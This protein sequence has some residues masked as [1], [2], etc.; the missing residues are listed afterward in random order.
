MMNILL[1]KNRHAKRETNIADIR[2]RTNATMLSLLCIFTSNQKSINEER[3]TNP[4]N[5]KIVNPILINTL[6]SRKYVDIHM[7]SNTALVCP[8][9]VYTLLRE[10]F[11]LRKSINICIKETDINTISINVE[12]LKYKYASK[13]V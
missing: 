1:E 3:N 9:I 10:L 5:G 8:A 13:D 6:S 11:T 12:V 2:E 7:K 4:R